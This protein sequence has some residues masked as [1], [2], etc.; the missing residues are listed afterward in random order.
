MFQ[1]K[2]SLTEQTN[3]YF[4]MNAAWRKSQRTEC[5]YTRK[6][7]QTETYACLSV[8][9]APE[10]NVLFEP[11]PFHTVRAGRQRWHNR[12]LLASHSTKQRVQEGE[13]DGGSLTQHQ[14]P[15]K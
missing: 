5:V 10:W 1:N 6:T 12:C 2:E 7:Q 11:T 3:F 4:L 14:H 15:P 9:T 8:T 13:I